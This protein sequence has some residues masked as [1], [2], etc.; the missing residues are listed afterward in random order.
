M[1][2]RHCLTTIADKLASIEIFMRRPSTDSFRLKSEVWNP[3]ANEI[4][5]PWRACEAMHWNMGV[6]EMSRRANTPLPPLA[7][8]D[9][10]LTPFTIETAHPELGEADLAQ[11][12]RILESTVVFEGSD[13]NSANGND[14]P[15]Y[16]EE[17]EGSKVRRQKIGAGIR[18]PRIAEL[19]EEI[20]A[21]ARTRMNEE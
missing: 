21:F 5:L 20:A 12:D 3:I 6:N 18:L 16:T 11:K 8:Y 14:D 19:D 10:S 4:G 7:V 13:L 15:A 1:C 2:S 17:E 9:S